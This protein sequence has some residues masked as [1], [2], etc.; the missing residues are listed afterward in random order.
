MAETIL[1]RSINRFWYNLGDDCLSESQFDL[2]IR[3]ME[4]SLDGDI[5]DLTSLPSENL[6][7]EQ[8]V[9]T[10]EESI[11]E[12][13]ETFLEL[14]EDSDSGEE[15]DVEQIRMDRKGE[16][17]SKG[18][19]PMDP[20][21]EDGEGTSRNHEKKRKVAED[22]YFPTQPKTIP[23]Q[24]TSP[25]GIINIDCQSNRRELIDDWIAEIEL[26]IRTNSEDYQDPDN[27]LLLMEHKSSG[28]VKELIRSVAWERHT[29]NLVEQVINGM[30]TMFLGLDYNNNQVA[31]K[32]KEKEQAKARLLKLQLCD[33]CYLEEFTCDYEKHMYKTEMRDFPGLIEQYLSKIPIIGEKALTRFRNEA[34]GAT[35]YSLGFAL[36]IV[37]EELSKICD[38][39]KKQK[40]LKK[41]NK[42]CCSIAEASVEYGCKKSEKKKYLKRYKKKK[43]KVYKPY[44]KKKKYRSGKY[45]KPK[46]KKGPKQKYC[47]K[48]KKN[49]RC[50][51]C[52]IE[53]HYAN[54]CPN[55]QSSEKAHVLQ[56]AEKLGLQPIEE[57]YEGVQEVFILEYEETEEE[58][59]SEEE[60]DGTSTSEDSD[61][62]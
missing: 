55:R 41:F 3:L 14:E 35:T 61:S 48:G 11:P 39:T 20:K 36:K 38:F 24:K 46:E 19:R 21:P 28:I 43:Y 27:I 52:N 59:T 49:C 17:D 29:G 47:P 62:D 30:Y 34:N 42:R 5:I 15:P 40:K 16:E 10:S 23:G 18:K 1:D 13:Q 26:I 25:I 7:V 8:I 54:E 37:K 31:E 9:S 22:R 58:E 33:I 6:Q 51:I 53:G 45:F 4:E 44:K 50:W 12:E 60:E 57:P 56:E 32:T 2:M